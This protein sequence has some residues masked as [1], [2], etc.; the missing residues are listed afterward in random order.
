MQNSQSLK[1]TAVNAIFYLLKTFG[2]LHGFRE[3]GLNLNKKPSIEMPRLIVLLASGTRGDVQ[4]Y[5][6]LALGLQSVGYRV[7]VATHANFQPLVESRGLPF[8]P[9][10]SNP[11]ELLMQPEW[12]SAL[13]FERGWGSGL[14][15]SFRFLRAARPLYER[16]LTTAWQACQGADAVIAGLP[17]LWGEHIA[18][19]LKVP[20]VYCLLQPLSRT[21]VF[22][23]ALFPWRAS[24]GRAYNWL[25]H[26]ALEQVLWQPW[27]NIIN[28]WRRGLLGLP[29]APLGGLYRRSYT[30][31]IPVLYGFSPTVLPEPAD[32]P[33]WHR[34]VGYWFLE[35]PG[36]WR[37]PPA[38]ERFVQA[39]TAPVFIGFGSSGRRISREALSLIQGAL[40]SAGLRGVLSIPG[41]MDPAMASTDSLFPV[42][43]VSHAWLF[44]RM[45]ALVHHGGAGTT[46]AGLKAGVPAL[47]MPQYADQFF[48][49]E[50]LVRL[51]AGPQPL[52][53]RDLT[54]DIFLAALQQVCSDEQMKL[55]LRSIQ[56]EI[57]AEAGVQQ[58]VEIIRQVL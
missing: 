46:A 44:P 20:C 52:P 24:L 53:P 27:R 51:G 57:L 25:S 4:P 29:N 50:R 42:Q 2:G 31:R 56:T 28:R 23:S 41:A 14:R 32:W 13:V 8:A 48:W 47:I 40:K 22:P 7:R 34:V 38:L 54:S 49:G 30:Q 33:A 9:L 15:A 19:A 10:E 26:L 5:I 43:E 21:T 37:P 35:E 3:A 18:E 12:E 39:G 1:Q 36:A 6:A 58:A 55:R 16:M 45:A 11:S 17:A